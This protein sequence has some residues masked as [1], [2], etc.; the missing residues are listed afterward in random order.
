M[1][2]ITINKS[3]ACGIIKA[4]PSKSHSH[5]LLIACG[6]S[7][8]DC[9]ISNIVL[10]EDIKA[11]INCLKTLGKDIEYINDTV[12]I[13][14]ANSKLAEE[15]VFD[16]N[17]SGST[18]RFFIPI[19]LT[20]GKKVIFK[21][22]EKLISRGIGVYQEIFDK[23]GIKYDIFKDKILIEGKLVSDIFKVVGNI[24]SQFISGLLFALP[25]LDEESKIIITTELES[26]NYIDMTLD[27]LKLTNIKV[28]QEEN[29][30][31]I[32]GKQTYI[33]NNFTAEG[34]YSNASFLD[35][36]NY[37][38]GNNVKIDGLNPNSSQ[39]DL[40][41]QELFAKLDQDYATIDL[42][43]CIDLGPIL[44]AF[45]SLKHGGHFINTKRLAI[46]ESNRILDLKDELEKFGV[47]VL[48]LENEVFIDNSSLHAPI[49]HLSGKND[50]R[51]VMA[52][53][54]ML[55]IYGGTIDGFE[56]VKKSYPSFFDDLKSLGVEVLYEQN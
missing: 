50:H 47:S 8:N 21:G 4:Q 12:Y 6:L 53:A 16:C 23:Q 19:A 51:I 30:F 28:I 17:E 29:T 41:Y 25:L 32:N 45:A 9:I 27:V 10:S 1:M 7:S 24:S 36:L 46:K 52:L 11:T 42:K 56:A 35:S 38:A 2:R 14:N 22:T 37:F 31:T 40:I 48:V 5:R 43:N 34:D 54:I 44:F 3:N 20:L 18:L 26:K 15:L 49:N 39:G 55:T 13:K 33:G